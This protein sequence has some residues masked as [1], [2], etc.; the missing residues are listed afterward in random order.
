MTSVLF[1]LSELSERFSKVFSSKLQRELAKVLPV[2]LD[3]LGLR[4]D[5]ER[6]ARRSADPPEALSPPGT[7]GP[8]RCLLGLFLGA[9]ESQSPAWCCWLH[10]CHVTR[11]GLFW[12]LGVGMRRR[13]ALQTQSS[14][15][16]RAFHSTKLRKI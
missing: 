7:V 2:L 4:T 14:E 10:T 6:Q 15:V 13:W 11:G 9:L 16:P 3:G 12:A 1:S 5:M 8:A